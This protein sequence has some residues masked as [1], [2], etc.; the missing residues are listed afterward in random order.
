MVPV[1]HPH[2]Q[3]VHFIWRTHRLRWTV[4]RICAPSLRGN[5]MF[6]RAKHDGSKQERQDQRLAMALSEHKYDASESLYPAIPR[7]RLLH[8]FER[9]TLNP[10]VRPAMRRFAYAVGQEAGAAR[11]HD[12]RTRRRQAVSNQGLRG[13]ACLGNHHRQRVSP[14]VLPPQTTEYLVESDLTSQFV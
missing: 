4:T 13:C 11:I 2:C 7:A 5:R 12:A 14:S 6:R 1:D 8:D 10:R 3:R 9:E